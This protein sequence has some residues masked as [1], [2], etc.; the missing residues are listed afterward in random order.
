MKAFY[1]R[2]EALDEEDQKMV[3]EIT[4]RTVTALEGGDDGGAVIII[5][6]A[7]GDGTAEM[8]AAGNQ[9]LIAPLLHSAGEVARKLFATPAGYTQ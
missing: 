7:H 9:Q 1:E 6:D 8:L 2:F 3:M 5:C 4:E